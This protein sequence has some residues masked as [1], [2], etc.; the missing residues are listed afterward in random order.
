LFAVP[1]L[2]PSGI[3]VSSFAGVVDATRSG[4]GVVGFVRRQLTRHGLRADDGAVDPK[5]GAV[6]LKGGAVDPKGVYSEQHSLVIA[7]PSLNRHPLYA[8]P[9]LLNG[10]FVN[11]R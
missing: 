8:G 4:E 10:W 2:P 1:P 7:P 9:N 3:D 11:E 6:D 5:G